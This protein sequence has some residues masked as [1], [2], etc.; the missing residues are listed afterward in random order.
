M[1]HVWYESFST[2]KQETRERALIRHQQ[3]A[4]RKFLTVL[5]P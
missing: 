5:H 2:V 3:Q 4:V 1:S